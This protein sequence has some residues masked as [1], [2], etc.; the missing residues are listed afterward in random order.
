MPAPAI[1]C[2]PLYIICAV[3]YLGVDG[4][5]NVIHI[6]KYVAIGAPTTQICGRFPLLDVIIF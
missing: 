6:L 4:W 5:N 3:F 1:F 2:A